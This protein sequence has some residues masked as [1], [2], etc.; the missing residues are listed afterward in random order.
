VAALLLNDLVFMIAIGVVAFL[1]IFF[2]WRKIKR[3]FGLL[4]LI[5]GLAGGSI[6]IQRFGVPYLFENV[7]APYQVERIMSMLGKDYVP[8]D[9]AKL[10]AFNKVKQMQGKLKDGEKQENYNVKQSKI[11]IGSGGLTGKGFLKGTVT[12]GAFVPEQHTDFIFTA[13]GETFGFWGSTLVVL[14]YFSLLMVII[15]VAE[16]QRSVFSRVYA[17]SVASVIFFHVVVNILMTMGLAPVI[18]IPLPLISYGG[19]SLLTFTVMIF[20]LIR[21]DADRQMIIR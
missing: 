5:L 14:L 1:A 4:L 18:G 6:G 10:E 9:E 21:L 20:I 19:S 15:N 16:R 3:N 7:M 2:N 8:R 11:A 12:Q 17:Y 13:I